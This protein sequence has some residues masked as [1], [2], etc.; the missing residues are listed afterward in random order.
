MKNRAPPRSCCELSNKRTDR[1]TSSPIQNSALVPPRYLS[2]ELCS[3]NRWDRR[4]DIEIA[5]RFAVTGEIYSC[6]INKGTDRVT[7]ARKLQDGSPPFAYADA[8]PSRLAERV[9]LRESD[10]SNNFKL[11]L[12]LRSC[13][14]RSRVTSHRDEPVVR[15]EIG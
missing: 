4:F 11:S 1:A 13:G 7:A 3:R 14:Q 9:H 10:A 12:S 15:M 2:V 6:V 8:Y 5:E